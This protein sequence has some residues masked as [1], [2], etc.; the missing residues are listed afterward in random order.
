MSRIVIFICLI[1]MISMPVFAG[2][3]SKQLNE[4]C[5][6]LEKAKNDPKALMSDVYCAAY[7]DG[8]VDGYRLMADLNPKMKFICLPKSGISNDA[9]IKVFSKWLNKN[10]KEIEL[11]ARSGVLLSLKEAYPCK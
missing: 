5:H 6:K 4:E 1:T 2:G 7:I 9:V 3:S 8:V 11:P 10:P